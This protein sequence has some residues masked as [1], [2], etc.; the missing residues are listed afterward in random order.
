MVPERAAVT[1]IGGGVVGSSI[2]YYLT[3]HGC[4]DV[5]VLERGM[6]SSG[7]TSKAAGGI[8]QQFSTEVN[9]RLSQA[10][11]DVFDP[12]AGTTRTRRFSIS[13]T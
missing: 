8:R 7:S 10:S 6:L 12:S 11:V 3:K 13:P 4:R 9:V 5:V 2:A 1:I